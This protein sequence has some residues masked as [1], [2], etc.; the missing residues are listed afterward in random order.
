MK[1]HCFKTSHQIDR[2][3]LYWTVRNHINKHTG[4]NYNLLTTADFLI[5]EHFHKTS[6][7]LK[8]N[9]N[10]IIYSTLANVY[11]RFLAKVYEG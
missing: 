2:R 7:F 1:S 8:I 11:R 5:P 10:I 9:S 3:V 4:K 6:I